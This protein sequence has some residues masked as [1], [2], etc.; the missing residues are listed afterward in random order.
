MAPQRR[1]RPAP[2]PEIAYR[3]IIE[4]WQVIFASGARGHTQGAEPATQPFFDETEIRVGAQLMEPFRGISQMEVHVVGTKSGIRHW[5]G[6]GSMWIDKEVIF[7]AVEVPALHFAATLTGFAAGQ[8]KRFYMTGDPARKR[9]GARVSML[10]LST[11]R[12]PDVE[13]A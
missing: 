13:D 4:G 1:P 10:V 2:S 3:G 11:E 6:I 7:A 9:G 12:D 5:P 8:V